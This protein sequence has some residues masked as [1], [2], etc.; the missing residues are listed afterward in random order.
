[1]PV[2]LAA[3]TRDVLRQRQDQ[4]PD[5]A[6]LEVD[7]AEA[8]TTGNPELIK[9]LIANLVDNAV[10]YNFAGG[11]VSVMTATTHAQARLSTANTGPT[12]Q[13]GEVTRLLRPFERLT[14][15]RA[16]HPDGHGLGLSIVAAIA[17]AHGADLGLKPRPAG[18]LEVAV[19]LPRHRASP[20][21]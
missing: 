14:G 7:L 11:H 8:W 18:G 21:S 12:I 1:D 4:L 9:R 13:A 20:G 6:E 19:A 5:D 15:E 3:L 2:E 16:S 17:A 10:R